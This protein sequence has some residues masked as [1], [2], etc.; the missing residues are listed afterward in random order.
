M[1]TFKFYR[2]NNIPRARIDNIVYTG[3]L[4]GSIPKR[5]FGIA[6]P[7]NP[8]TNGTREW[9]NHQGITYYQKPEINL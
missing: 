5:C 6:H 2:R 1:K 4:I 9:F 7:N 3:F 8:D